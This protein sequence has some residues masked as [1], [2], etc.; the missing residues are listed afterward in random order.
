MELHHKI[1]AVNY[2]ICNKNYTYFLGQE[3]GEHQITMFEEVTINGTSYIY[4]Y[5]TNTNDNTQPFLRIPS[6][7]CVVTY[8]DF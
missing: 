8:E 7:I 4:L 1:K 5:S 2:E 6:S 3:L